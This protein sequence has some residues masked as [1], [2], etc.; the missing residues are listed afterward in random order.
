MIGGFAINLHGYNRSTKDIDIWIEDTLEN[1]KRLRKALKNK[2]Q[3][4]TLPSKQ[5]ILYPVGPIFS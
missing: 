1:R 5:W 2:V 3:V 4:I